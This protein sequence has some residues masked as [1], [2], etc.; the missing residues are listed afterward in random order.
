MNAAVQQLLSLQKIDS[1]VARVQDKIDAIPRE[2]ERRRAELEAI[3]T[4]WTTHDKRIRE[5][6][7]RNGELEVKVLGL[8]NAIKRQEE[9]R[10]K[11][12]NASTFEAAQ[13]Q[14]AYLKEDREKLQAEQFELMELLEKL[15]PEREEAAGRLAEAE[16]AFAAYEV[17][18]RALHD[19]LVAQRDGIAAE[20]AAFLGGVGPT[21]LKLYRD[22]FESR[23]GQA[24]VMVEGQFCGGCYT[25]ITPND[26]ARLQT[27]AG[28]VTC[29]ACGRILYLP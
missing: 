28:I 19:E 22:L 13:H 29:K 14:I 12:Q 20:R 24:V 16:A 9:H 11:A 1:K 3:R 18:A 5:A 2:T 4:T 17:E 26:M 21:E 27:G 10:D 23:E 15:G 6:E 8:D 25:K 7:V